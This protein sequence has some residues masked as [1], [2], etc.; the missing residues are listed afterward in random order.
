MTSIE[1]VSLVV[2]Q[3]H[4]S[5]ES[6]SLVANHCHCH[7]FCFVCSVLLYFHQLFI[8]I[9]KN[10]HLAQVVVRAYA[11][12]S[13]ANR[14]AEVILAIIFQNNAETMSMSQESVALERS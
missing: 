9:A 11:H 8:P 14:S 12:N 7:Q 1:S 2:S 13:T 4:Y 10:L 6:L 3:Y 5:S